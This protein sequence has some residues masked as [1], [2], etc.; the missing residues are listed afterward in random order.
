[1]IVRDKRKRWFLE[2]E[3]TEASKV[4]AW[5]YYR[6]GAGSF[7][8]REKSGRARPHLALLCLRQ[9]RFSQGLVSPGIPEWHQQ[10]SAPS[11]AKPEPHSGGD[12]HP[13]FSVIFMPII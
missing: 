5:A 7:R 9:D 1:M 2:A 6:K 12:S 11:P 8:S 13:S 10:C 3:E 4:L